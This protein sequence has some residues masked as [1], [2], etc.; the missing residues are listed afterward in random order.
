MMM[1]DF[2]ADIIK[3]ERPGIGDETR[4]W[5]PPFA[6]PGES[7]YFL[8]VNRNKRSITID[9]K[10]PAGIPVKY[11]EAKATIRK[12]PPVLGEHTDEI[13]AEILGYD[14]RRIEELKSAGVL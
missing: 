14:G 3:V 4:H 5:G 6:A 1:G 13:L 12:P 9:L 10:K 7:A 8:C 11:S 2:G